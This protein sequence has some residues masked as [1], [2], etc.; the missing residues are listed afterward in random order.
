MLATLSLS[1]FFLNLK[2]KYPR[3]LSDINQDGCLDAAEFAVAMHLVQRYLQGFSL[4][5]TLPLPLE[6]CYHVSL[7][8]HLPAATQKHVLKCKRIFEAFN[9]DLARGA[10]SGKT[11]EK[12]AMALP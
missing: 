11:L 7:K 6:D 5:P 12:Y 10:L 3:E 4:P 2:M 1:I 8:P 9:Q